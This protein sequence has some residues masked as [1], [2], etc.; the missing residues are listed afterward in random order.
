M[1]LAGLLF[2]YRIYSS[3]VEQDINK[4]VSQVRF[5]LNPINHVRGKV[6]KS[7]ECIGDTELYKQ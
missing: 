4:S 7:A 3:V 5:L 2:I 1:V 6:Q